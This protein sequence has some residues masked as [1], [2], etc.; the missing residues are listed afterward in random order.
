MTLEQIKNILI[1][2]P[3]IIIKAIETKPEL[4]YGLLIKII[5]FEKLA[6]KEDIKLIIELLNKRFEAIDKRFE[7]MIYH[8][9]KHFEAINKRFEDV[10]NRFEDINRR[11]EDINKRFEDMRYYIDKR[12]GFL[13]KIIIGFNIPILVGLIIALVRLFI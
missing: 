8:T 3:E 7:D 5:P 10:N 13:E 1:E 6:T 9:D 12:I 2:H 11:F 4:F